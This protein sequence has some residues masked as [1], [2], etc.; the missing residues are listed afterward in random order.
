MALSVLDLEIHR[1]QECVIAQGLVTHEWLD[2]L[3]SSLPPEYRA[4]LPVPTA[5]ALR[6][7]QSL[8]LL[9]DSGVLGDG[10]LPLA[11]V[12]DRLALES[13]RDVVDAAKRVREVMLRNPPAS[14][15]RLPPVEVPAVYDGPPTV[16]LEVT[17]TDRKN[18]T[19]R[20]EEAGTR[21]PACATVRVSG[22]GAETPPTFA[23]RHR[24]LFGGGPW[25]T[26]AMTPIEDGEAGVTTW[27][28]STS[29]RVGK[30]RAWR[31][32]AKVSAGDQQ[33]RR[34]GLVVPRNGVRVAITILI[35]LAAFAVIWVLPLPNR[36]RLL[37]AGAVVVMVGAG[38]VRGLL[39]NTATRGP[40]CGVGTLEW[41]AVIAVLGAALVIALPPVLM[42]IVENQTA[43]TVVIHKRNKENLQFAPGQGQT[44]MTWDSELKSIDKRDDL[45]VCPTIAGEGCFCESESVR[46]VTVRHVKCKRAKWVGSEALAEAG[47]KFT[48]A[49][50]LNGAVWRVTDKSCKP[51]DAT[52]S[53]DLAMNGARV[54]AAPMVGE[55]PVIV[56]PSM[57]T[58]RDAGVGS[59]SSSEPGVEPPARNTIA[60]T[61]TVHHP[62]TREEIPLRLHGVESAHFAITGASKV[63]W[64]EI[65]NLDVKGVYA[66]PAIGA[67]WRELAV[68]T[69]E[70]RLQ[71]DL[72]T[73][74][75]RAGVDL[76]PVTGAPD[77]TEVVLR[78]QQTTSTWIP[79]TGKRAR[80]CMRPGELIRTATV[81]VP[82]LEA[83]GPIVLPAS[84]SLEVIG[85]AGGKLGA[86]VSCAQS[87]RRS[88]PMAFSIIKVER[89]IDA[90]LRLHEAAPGDRIW[91]I[92]PV[93]VGGGAL[94]VLCDPPRGPVKARDANGAEYDLL[95]RVLRQAVARVVPVAPTVPIPLP[96]PVV[97]HVD[98]PGPIEPPVREPCAGR[99]PCP[100]I[101][102]VLPPVCLVRVGAIPKVFRRLRSCPE[103]LPDEPQTKCRKASDDR[104]A[105]VFE[106]EKLAGR[107]CT[108][109]CFCD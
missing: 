33:M 79:S 109:V 40:L 87:R 99:L 44:L 74:A 58:M 93:S 3:F 50:T 19:W 15:G 13:I 60:G 72:G 69:T 2:S 71:C 54:S 38:L 107:T 62:W 8:A 39:R 91:D 10:T 48:G 41:A 59:G 94:A 108:A 77:K 37:G 32:D 84:R 68:E 80:A 76:F 75:D 89:P 51:L 92:A 49:D 1:L 81:T 70:G 22:E 28:T 67:D 83:L 90:P 97:P 34:H 55:P 4:T 53:V 5:P 96:R 105:P 63:P 18:G 31:L 25:Q 104:A 86:A 45:C 101:R 23:W 95:P 16:K 29:I 85:L 17:W 106:H 78:G 47:E 82:Q 65:A 27:R 88:E 11:D 35:A 103:V 61:M 73:P 64:L 57:P 42:V 20:V 66:L 43:D 30:L 21:C 7:E 46:W 36:A 12:V 100:P 26:A 14:S 52:A 102:R 6:L 24:R 56:D 98:P 9:A